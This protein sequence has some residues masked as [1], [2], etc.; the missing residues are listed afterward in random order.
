MNKINHFNDKVIEFKE[1]FYERVKHPYLQKFIQDPVVDDDKILFLYMM[2]SEQQLPT[3]LVKECVLSSMLVQAALDTHEEVSLQNI[4]SDTIKKNHQLTVLAGD[5]YSSLYYFLL[6]K[7][8]YI[9]MI[10][11]FSRSIQE[12]NEH[13]MSV[14]KNKQSFEENSRD[15]RVIESVLLQNIANHFTLTSW[16]TFYEQ[17]FFLKRFIFERNQLLYGKKLPLIRSFITDFISADTSDPLREEV[18]SK[19]LHVCQAHIDATRSELV[20]LCDSFPKH[21]ELL[22]DRI[23]RLMKDGHHFNEK[24]AEEG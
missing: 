17:F 1:C 22:L 11:V 4:K 8:N 16:S 23:D 18:L 15:V 21:K 2:L 10:R 7:N 13:K 9:S 3:K 6:S 20:A 14:Y 12:S 24:V 19:V 5:F